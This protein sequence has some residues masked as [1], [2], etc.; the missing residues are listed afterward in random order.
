[1][2]YRT[3][4]MNNIDSFMNNIDSCLF[5][6]LSLLTSS[7]LVSYRTKHKYDVRFQQQQH[8]QEHKQQLLYI[9][10]NIWVLRMTNAG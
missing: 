7:N 5:Q 1:M 6:N 2:I 4:V 9:L 10:T 3:E 8:R